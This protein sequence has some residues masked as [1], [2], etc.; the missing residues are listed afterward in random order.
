[1]SK[2]MVVVITGGSS[3]PG[4]ALAQRFIKD[5]ASVALIALQNS[6]L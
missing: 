1:M 3:G 4:K 5:G 6:L 2:S